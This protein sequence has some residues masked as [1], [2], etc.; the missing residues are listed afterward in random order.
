MRDRLG[1]HP[2]MLHTF[3]ELDKRR[4]RRATLSEAKRKREIE[5]AVDVRR[6]DEDYVWS[7]WTVRL[8][9]PDF[10]FSNLTR[11]LRVARTRHT[12]KNARH[13]SKSQTPAYRARTSGYRPGA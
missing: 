4:D 9:F 5:L 11:S 13:R 6:T 8:S 3:L 10:L 1:I 12:P 2:E 7:W